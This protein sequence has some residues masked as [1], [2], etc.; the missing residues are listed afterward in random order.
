MSIIDGWQVDIQTDFA[1]GLYQEIW[2][3]C[4]VIENDTLGEE[5]RT[6][7]ILDY[8]DVDKIIRIGDYQQVHMAQRFR[9]PY[10][11]SSTGAWQ[12]PDFTLRYSRPTSD[13][14]VEYER[15][16]KAH[17]SGAAAY[18]RRYSF[19]RAYNDADRGLYELYI[20]DVDLLIEGITSGEIP[21]HQERTTDE[22]QVFRAY[23]LGDIVAHGAVV[24][25]MRLGDNPNP[26]SAK[27]QIPPSGQAKLE[28][29]GGL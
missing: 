1:V 24:E 22:G 12:D 19:G 7:Q 29:W 25:K 16:M 20:I 2:N 27:Y 6:A 21:L 15:L 23:E 5:E 28:A 3:K 11:D 14:P 13:K 4:E 8:G 9:K 10:Y 18:P 26:Q 17:D